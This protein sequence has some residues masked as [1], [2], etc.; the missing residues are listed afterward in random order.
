M[1]PEMIRAIAAQQVADWQAEAQARLRVKL[2]RQARR[3]RRH[4]SSAPDPLA[5]VRVPDYVDGTSRHGTQPTEAQ[6]RLPVKLARQARRA[7]RHSSSAPDPLAG[8]RV[9]DYVDGTSRHGTQPAGRVPVRDRHRLRGA[10]HRRRPAA[11]R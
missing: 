7:R 1:H 4:S 6:A 8:V 9:P 3:A 2:A 5:G 11:R 10:H